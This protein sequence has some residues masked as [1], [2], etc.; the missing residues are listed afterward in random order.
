MIINKRLI[1]QT[2]IPGIFDSRLVETY[3]LLKGLEWCAFE[4]Y[5]KIK[6]KDGDVEIKFGKMTVE[7]CENFEGMF[8]PD[9]E[10][11]KLP[12]YMHISTKIGRQDSIFGCEKDEYFL[13]KGTKEYFTI[14]ES[15]DYSLTNKE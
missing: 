14:K 8:G 5:I 3:R 9:V 4:P 10:I 7:D 1:E 13:D 6:S 11:I 12:G 15:Q 2:T